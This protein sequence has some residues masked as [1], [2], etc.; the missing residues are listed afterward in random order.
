[1]NSMKGGVSKDLAFLFQRGDHM[2]I[3]A[4]EHFFKPEVR[5]S[6]QSYFKKGVVR[7]AQP[8]DTEVQAF[9]RSSGNYKVTFKSPSVESPVISVDCTCP[10]SQK[11][12]FCKHVW[13][14]LLK[15]EQ[16]HSDFLDG[17]TDIQKQEH[18]EKA[19]EEA[20]SRAAEIQK[21][22][23]SP[24]Q[25]Q[26]KKPLSQEQVEKREAYKQKQSDYRKQQYQ[27]QKQRLKELKQGE[28]VSKLEPVRP[29]YPP[30][31][32][33]ALK[34]FHQNGFEMEETLNAEILRLA[35][36]HLSRVFHPDKG[37][38]HEEI[39]DLNRNAAILSEF[40]ETEK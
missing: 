40:L 20:S 31:V 36:K 30:K 15:V 5:S 9:I 27:K 8:S 35:K 21:E 7:S 22:S 38:S 18:A 17:K 6:G 37:G 26:A 24:Y 12:Q 32:K 13:A 2:S 28:K 10:T 19:E 33:E 39:V 14:T 11:G 1:M 23:K 34:F 3:E 29:Q 16:S 25:F 4:W